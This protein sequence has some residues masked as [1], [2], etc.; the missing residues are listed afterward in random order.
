M[1]KL[2]LCFLAALATTSSIAQNVGI[3]TVVPQ[4]RLHVADSSVL[5]AG[6]PAWN[7]PF[8]PGNT[9]ANGSGVRLLWYADKAAF[10]AGAVSANVWDADSI[11]RWSF[12]AGLDSKAKGDYSVSLGVNNQSLAL[13]SFTAGAAN[14]TE[15]SYGIAIG[16][17]STAQNANSVALGN[18]LVSKYYSGTVIGTFNDISDGN[19]NPFFSLPGDRVFQIGNGSP[20]GRSNAI[21]ILRNGNAGIG[22]LLPR[23]RLHVD[24]SVVFTS[25]AAI[26]PVIQADPPVS[27]S[28]IRMMWYPDK[29]AFRSGY[30]NGSQWDKNNTG[31]YSFAAGQNNTASGRSTVAMGEANT[32]GADYATAI[33]FFNTAG[34]RAVSMGYANTASGFSTVA[35]G[36][37][38]SATGNYAVSIGANTKA[39]GAIS[40]SMG[41]NAEAIGNNSVSIGHYTKARSDQ[42]FVAGRFNDTSAVGRLFEIGNGTADNN[43]R[44][45]VTV[46]TTGNMGIGTTNPVRPLSFP[47]V[48]GEKILLYPGSTGEVGI[49]VYG[50]ELRIHS[51]YAAARISFG[52]QDNAGNF[53]QT[54]WLNNTTSVLTVGGTAYPSDERFKENISPIEHPLQK[55]AALHGVEYNM[56]KAHFPEMNFSSER[57]TGLLAQEVELVMPSAV[58]TIHEKGYKG[59][60]YAKLV[61]L[62]IESIKAQ[63]VQIDNLQQELRDLLQQKTKL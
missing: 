19:I 38:T 22:T 1:H 17:N 30:V 25:N 9:P 63:Q 23:A 27:G 5:F 28:G 59:V 3:G 29:A 18:D 7:L 45:A 24:S 21:T 52:Y 20:F 4:A 16:Y 57:Q 14:T 55:I 26:I 13:G 44:N 10:R 31:N 48:L 36:F 60:D 15:N 39:K 11:G 41:D 53:T 6:S 49:G 2:S 62:L 34:E 58:Y 40:L 51:D 43:R 54:M 33:G 37:G 35:M 47:P 12:A 32:A 46:L 61:P 56:R 8:L 50:N 42:S